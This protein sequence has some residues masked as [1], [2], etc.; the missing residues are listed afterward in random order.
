MASISFRTFQAFNE[1]NRSGSVTNVPLDANG[2]RIACVYRVPYFPS[3]TQFDRFAFLVASIT[4]TAPTYDFRLETVVD[5]LPSGTLFGTNTHKTFQPTATGYQTQSLIAA[6]TVSPGDLIA[7]VIQRD[8]GTADG[9]N[10]ASFAHRLSSAARADHIG[11]AND[12]SVGTWTA[13]SITNGCF[14]PM[15]TDGCLLDDCAIISTVAATNTFNTGSTPDERGIR[16]TAYAN[17]RCHGAR[18]FI[19]LANSATATI[20]LYDSSNTLLASAQLVRNGVIGTGAQYTEVFWAAGP[21]DLAVGSDYRLTVVP[22]TGNNVTLNTGTY[23][24]AASRV[25]CVGSM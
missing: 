17:W 21:V 10:F 7:A 25:A 13:N 5:G 11:P 6:A 19:G 22:D 23:A 8:S 4:G 9:S 1:Y 20:K 15:F 2:D 12:L 16:F 24:A 14:G 3:V 18:M